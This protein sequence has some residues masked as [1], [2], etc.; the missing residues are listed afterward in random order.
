MSSGGYAVVNSTFQGPVLWRGPSDHNSGQ[1]FRVRVQFDWI[2][3]DLV[4]LASTMARHLLEGK[5]KTSGTKP[6]KDRTFHWSTCS[7]CPSPT[8]RLIPKVLACDTIKIP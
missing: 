2:L 3:V 1:R 7:F 4:D 6:G 5:K 8:S